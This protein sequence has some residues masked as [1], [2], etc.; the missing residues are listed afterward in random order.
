MGRG[1]RGGLARAKSNEGTGRE[2]RREVAGDSARRGV[3]HGAIGTGLREKAS[4]RRR[5]S[6]KGELARAPE[7]RCFFGGGTRLW[8]AVARRLD[9]E[10]RAVHKRGRTS[11]FLHPNASLRALCV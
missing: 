4:A 1:L 9:A 2:L 5:S 3:C 6:I 10:R 11:R 8:T 7:E